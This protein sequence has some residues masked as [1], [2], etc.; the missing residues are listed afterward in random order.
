MNKDIWRQILVIF[1]TAGVIIVN[2]LANALPFNGLSTGEVSDRFGALFVPAGYV[3]SIWGL[4][5]IG[6]I[7]YSIFQALPRQR[8]NPRLRAIAYLYCLSC[9]A[10]AVWLLLWHYLQFELTVLVMLVL[11][12]LLIMIYLRLGVNKIDVQL[13][14]RLTTRFTFSIYLGWITVA[15][16]ANIS[17]VLWISGW[18]GAPL[19]ESSWALIMMAAGVVIAYLMSI[20][21]HDWA[22]I[23]VLIWAFVGIAIKQTSAPPV[24]NGAWAFSAALGVLAL[25]AMIRIPHRG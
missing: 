4:I 10:N 8:E 23:L 13:A 17:Q 9:L 1:F 7:A 11:L 12:V 3:F 15:T 19:Q 5:Y 14:E 2:G 24:A 20:L 18:R 16:I 25:A 21:R 6:L 22:Y